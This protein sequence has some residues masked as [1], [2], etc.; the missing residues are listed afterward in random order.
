MKAALESALVSRPS[1]R[2]INTSGPLV[3]GPS[4]PCAT[5]P[6]MNLS[7]PPMSTPS[8]LNVFSPLVIGTGVHLYVCIYV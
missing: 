3:S 1:G 4:G 8:A 7:G 2:S 5:G 6:L